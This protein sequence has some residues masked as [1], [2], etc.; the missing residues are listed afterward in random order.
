MLHLIQN[1]RRISERYRE[2]EIT[3][4]AAQASFFIVLSAVPFIMLLLSLIHFIPAINKSDL[5]NIL[6][7]MLPDMLDALVISIVDDLY[8]KSPATV[9]SISAVAAI[10][11]AEK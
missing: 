9:V 10:W 1:I 6:T 8:T 5:M 2:D 7:R 4:Y 3:V 11:S